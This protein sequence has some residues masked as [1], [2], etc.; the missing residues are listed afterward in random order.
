MFESKT[1]YEQVPLEAVKK[2]DR[3]QSKEH[4]IQLCEQASIEQDP[5]RLLALVREINELLEK[6]HGALTRNKP[7]GAE[8]MGLV[9]V[10]ADFDG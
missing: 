6:K 8:R 4:W 7:M 1:H 5:Q 3:E 2:M 9:A 10:N